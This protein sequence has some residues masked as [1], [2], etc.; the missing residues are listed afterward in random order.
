[1]P[2]ERADKSAMGQVATWLTGQSFNNVLLLM[3][4]AAIWL[5]GEYA[6]KTAIPAHLKQIQNGYETIDSRHREERIELREQYDKLL[7]QKLASKSGP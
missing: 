7:Q 4:L 6:V 3:I 1:M 5:G 2:E